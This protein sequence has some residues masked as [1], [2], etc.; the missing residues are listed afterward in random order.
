[1][2]KVFTNALVIV[3]AKDLSQ[4]APSVTINYASEILDQT[5]MGD[6]TRS[7]IGGLKDWSF[8][9]QFHYDCST[10]GPEAV[11]WPLVGT[12]SCWEVRPVNACS[13]ANNPIYSGIGI[14]D[15]VPMGGQVGTLLI[16]TSKV[17]SVSTLSRAS[18]C[19]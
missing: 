6:D 19:S 17:V 12:S 7:H 10:A 2:A 8:D 5:A 11:L 3:N 18:S 16:V 1:M 14:L 9:M 15:G 4:Y 13:S